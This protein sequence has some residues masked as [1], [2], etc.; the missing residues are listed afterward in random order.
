[1][2][3][4]LLHVYVSIA[5]T[6]GYDSLGEPRRTI[7]AVVCVVAARWAVPAFL[8]VSGALLLDPA[9]NVGWD[10]IGRYVRR[11][12][13]VL[14]TFGLAFC[15][16]E[17]VYDHG[18]FSLDVVGEALLNLLTGH[19]WDHLWYVY[20]LLALYLLTPALRAV[21]QRVSPRA[22][23][24]G[25]LAAYALVLVL[26]TLLWIWDVF[27]STPF[28][29]VPA[30]FYYVLGWFVVSQLRLDQRVL[31]AGIV[32]L[33]AVVVAA[34]VGYDVLALPE[35][36]LVAPYAVLVLLLFKEHATTPIE[37]YPWA[38]ML[39]S[40]SFGI[41]VIHPLFLHAITHLIDPLSAPAGLYELGAFAVAL[42]A[43]IVFVRALRMI[44]VFRKY[45]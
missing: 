13:F 14:G 18:G 39:A 15:L 44:P 32:S 33:V 1:M 40:C 25:L 7:D 6:V 4:V 30:V 5:S 17:S 37:R 29:V 12:L 43:S 35:Y 8:M 22:L 19:S 20:A 3:I 21:V 41:Y 2:A 31:V 10:R 16:I 26:P 11:M 45:L 9:R 42:A 38:E 24:W 28:N 34:V 36:C 27:V 23:G